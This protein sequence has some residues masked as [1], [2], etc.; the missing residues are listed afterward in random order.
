MAAE[1]V[2]VS[3][4]AAI[5]QELESVGVLVPVPPRRRLPLVYCRIE[6]SVKALPLE[7]V[8]L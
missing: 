3:R 7:G 5:C 4:P 6:R 2:S 8:S 1:K